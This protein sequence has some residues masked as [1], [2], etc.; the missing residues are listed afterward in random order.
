M[1]GPVAAARY[2][3]SDL[4]TS[5]FTEFLGLIFVFAAVDPTARSR[6]RVSEGPLV[7]AERLFFVGVGVWLMRLAFRDLTRMEYGSLLGYVLLFCNLAI[8]ATYTILVLRRQREAVDWPTTQAR[9]ESTNVRSVAAGKHHYYSAELAYSYTVA[10]EYYAGHFERSFDKEQE[11]WEFVDG[12]RGTAIT[13]RYRPA[14]P[15]QSVVIE[16]DV[17]VAVMSDGRS[18]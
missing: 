10:G 4:L 18:S 13:A 2:G 17:K 5:L 16:A 7:W 12:F 3:S 14:D 6:H 9:V 8:A 15:Q 11:A 1:L